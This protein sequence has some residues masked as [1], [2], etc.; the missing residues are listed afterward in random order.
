MPR[1]S[2]IVP[3]YNRISEI[4][5]L[6]DS[7][8]RQ[9]SHDFETINVEDGSTEP[10]DEVVNAAAAKGLDVRYY[11]KENEG[12]S[13]ARNYGLERAKGDYFVFFDSDCVIPPGYFTTL[14]HMLDN[15]ALDC[16]S[17]R[18]TEG[19]KLLDDIVHDHRRNTWRKN[20]TRE[21]C[22]AYIQHGLLT[23]GI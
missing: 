4:Q 1:F 15:Q 17:H 7:L 20:P 21:I 9:T 16:F 10:C 23:Q 12:R 13:I 19:H 3:V 22:A 14:G 2:I 6:L 5:D 11:F 18:H 8:L